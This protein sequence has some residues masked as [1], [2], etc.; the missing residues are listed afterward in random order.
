MDSLSEFNSEAPVICGSALLS[1]VIKR[2]NFM[3]AFCC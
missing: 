2:L 1:L 3:N